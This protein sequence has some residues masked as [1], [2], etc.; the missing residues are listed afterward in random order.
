M[1]TQKII[2]R[3]MLLE[4]YL[5]EG[6]YELKLAGDTQEANERLHEADGV[7][8]AIKEIEAMENE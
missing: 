1:T 8:Y 4:A 3:L 6:A 2:K 7:M 5:R